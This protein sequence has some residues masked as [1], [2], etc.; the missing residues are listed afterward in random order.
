[1]YEDEFMEIAKELHTLFS[2]KQKVYGDSYF[3]E[4]NKLARFY[5]GIYRKF[6]R[7]QHFMDDSKSTQD[8]IE[9]LDETYGDLAIYAIMELIYFKLNKNTLTEQEVIEILD[10]NIHPKKEPDAKMYVNTQK[11]MRQTFASSK[12]TIFYK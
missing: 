11:P 3:R 8:S 6:G 10:K 7:L 2:K 1:M 12:K 9:S 4:N 5:G